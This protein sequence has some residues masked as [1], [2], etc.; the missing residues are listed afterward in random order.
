VVLVGGGVMSATLGALL[1]ELLPDQTILAFE[2]LDTIAA[3]SS[4]VMN[5]AGT[6]HAGLC[7]LNYTPQGADGHVDIRKAVQVHEAFE[8]ALQFWASLVE[9]GMLP[10]PTSFVNPVPHVSFVRGAADVRFLRA[11]HAALDAHPLFAG[12][13]YGEDHGV[14]G[15]WMPL[16]MEGR[17]ADEPVAATRVD[18]GTDVD[19]GRL[20]RSLFTGLQTRPGFSLRVRH[21]VKWLKRDPAGGWRLGVHDRGTGAE[22]E[23]HARFVFLGAGGGAL[24]LL[25]KAG[26]PEAR[27]YGGFPVNGQWLVC[28]N[29]DVIERH[30]VKVYGKAA[31]GAPPMSVPHLDARIWN[32]RASLLFGPYAGFTTRYLRKGSPLD[33]FSSLRLHNLGPMLSVARQNLDLIGY[34]VG[35]SLQSERDRLEALR[36]YVPEARAEDWKLQL[37]GQRVQIIKRGPD[38]RGRLEFGT[39]LVVTADGS[40]A[41]LLGAS[42]G[43]STAVSSMLELIER[44]FPD[45][46][47]SPE[48]RAE[49]ARLIPSRGRS[50]TDEPDLLHAVRARVDDV[51]Q[52]ET[53]LPFRA[54]HDPLVTAAA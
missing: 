18:R 47:A 24:P 49:L 20:T 15:E 32:G 8:E 37:A 50:L 51:L 12:M 13:A 6:G 7:E 41:A 5:N 17:P 1:R 34:L 52:L 35:Q 54:A 22:R 19:F 9:D 30:H 46:A 48:Y 11:R 44:C 31:L 28:T 23:V 42:P 43:A 45:R 36:E 4:Q 40:L 29:P 27:G 21:E 25:Q 38:G 39:E 3:E 14:L 16:V 53:P 2:R 26:V 10:E 33:L